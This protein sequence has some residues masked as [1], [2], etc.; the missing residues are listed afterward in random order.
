MPPPA[1]VYPVPAMEL[2]PGLADD[3]DI[4][5]VELLMTPFI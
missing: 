3:E 4:V 5:E 2:L 1:P